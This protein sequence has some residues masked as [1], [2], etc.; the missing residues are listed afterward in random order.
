MVVAAC[1]GHA[2]GE[3]RR[4]TEDSGGRLGG[5]GSLEIGSL[6]VRFYVMPAVTVGRSD[7]G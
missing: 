2:F 1:L 4:D 3:E 7:D 6:K 5:D